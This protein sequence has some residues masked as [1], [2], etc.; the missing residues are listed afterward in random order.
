MKAKVE[1]TA[2]GVKAVIEAKKTT[3][4]TKL[5]HELGYKGSVSSS[6]TRKLR[7][8][9][10]GID[11]MLKGAAGPDKGDGCGKAKA[12]AP[13]PKAGKAPKG[14][15]KP[16]AKAGK[17]PRDGRNPFREGSAYA[18]CFDILAAHK[19]GLPRER[20]VELLAKATGKDAVHAGYDAQVLLSAHGNE[21]GLS[22]NEGPRHRSCRPG[23]WV[24]RTNGH[25]TLMV[26]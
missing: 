15:A 8:L 12:G 10:P 22:R 18:T 1:I 9:V 14:K 24:K 16:A 23:F 5:A 25:V 19:D 3:S 17:C 7:A 13:G 21:P 11:G 4:M 6:L 26:D 20:L 2:E